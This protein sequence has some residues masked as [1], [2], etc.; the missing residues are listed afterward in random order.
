MDPIDILERKDKKA[1]EEQVPEEKE[2]LWKEYWLR[3]KDNKMA[4]V[5]L[6]ILILFIILAIFANWI[7]P[8]SYRDQNLS[9]ALQAPSA[10]HWFGTDEYGRD[11]FSRVVYGAR[12]SLVIGFFAVIG[13]I[14]IGSILGV[15]AGYYGRWIDVIISRVFDIML[16]FPSILLAIAIV[17][18]LGPSLVNVLIAIGTLEIPIFG[19]LIRSVVL[20]IREDEYIMA[21]RSI[22]MKNSRILFV[23]ILPNSLTS[24]IVQGTLSFALAI[25]SAASLG[26]LGLGAQPP[27]PEWGKMLADSQQYIQEAP[28]TVFFPGLA[29]ML[30]VI[31]LN[32][33]GDGLRDALDPK[34]GE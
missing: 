33:I 32:L 26:F 20:S 28:W 22:G 21:A 34:M 2:G 27:Q 18:A 16:S 29:I 6:G 13:A 15:I 9:Q 4:L 11:V 25:L 10:D 24:I 17:A 3:F 7:A 31:S 8:E 30:V 1:I 14:I 23:H 12:I 19:R 5:G